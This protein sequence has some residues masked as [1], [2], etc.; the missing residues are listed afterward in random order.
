MTKAPNPP[1]PEGCKRPAAPPSPPKPQTNAFELTEPTAGQNLIELA[2]HYSMNG[3]LMVCCGCKR[4]QQVS[5]LFKPFIHASACKQ[6]PM[7]DDRPWLS[8]LQTMVR[9]SYERA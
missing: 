1:P 5:H 6:T 3:D 7:H 8:V 4:G 2:D 9:A